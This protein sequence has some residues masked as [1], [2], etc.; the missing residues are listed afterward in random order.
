MAEGA[1]VVRAA[2]ARVQR[3]GA[4]VV[5]DR[6]LEAAQLAERETPAQ[7]VHK[8][9]DICLNCS[10]HAPLVSIGKGDK[11]PR[12][13]HNTFPLWCSRSFPR[14]FAS[15]ALRLGGAPVVVEVR[16]LSVQLDGARKVLDCLRV[17]ALHP[18]RAGFPSDPSQPWLP[19]SAR[20][21]RYFV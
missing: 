6:V 15:Q 7:G 18:Q 10:K 21:A 11:A 14:R 4:A 19:L 12:M 20:S 8:Q 2:V 16:V 17:L 3:N 9:S 1:V 5:H 13:S